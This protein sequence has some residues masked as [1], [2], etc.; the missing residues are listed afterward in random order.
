MSGTKYFTGL[1]AGALIGGV[2]GML[3]APK[4]GKESRVIVASRAT[5]LKHKASGYAETLREKVLK[6]KVESSN[7]NSENHI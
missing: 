3:L 7:G 2:A 5:E 1:L 6:D 4:P